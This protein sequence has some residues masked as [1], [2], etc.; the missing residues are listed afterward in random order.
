MKYQKN[1]S[2][3]Q[4]ETLL[5]ALRYAL[6]SGNE[7][8]VIADLGESAVHAGSGHESLLEFVVSCMM[9]NEETAQLIL[10]CAMNFMANKIM[11][12]VCDKCEKAET[13][14]KKKKMCNP[15]EVFDMIK[16]DLQEAIKLTK[17]GLN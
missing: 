12:D 9:A 1:P 10:N 8:M 15:E 6:E 11:H 14:G 13:C 2:K 16:N 5:E 4:S 7:F 17:S 3:E